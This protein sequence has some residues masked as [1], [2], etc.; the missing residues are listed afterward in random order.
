MPTILITKPN[1]TEEENSRRKEIFFDILS[2]IAY[3]DEDEDE[4]D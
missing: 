4:E 2:D 1:I 3:Q